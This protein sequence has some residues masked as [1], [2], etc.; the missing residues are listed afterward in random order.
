MK[1]KLKENG[2][3]GHSVLTISEIVN[4][5]YEAGRINQ[6]QLLAFQQE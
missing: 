4:T 2:Y 6:Q 3:S 5:L 1:D